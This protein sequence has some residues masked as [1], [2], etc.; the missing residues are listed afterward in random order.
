MTHPRCMRLLLLAVASALLSLTAAAQDSTSPDHTAQMDRLFAEYTV[1][2]S[3]GAAVG[4]YRHGKILFAKGY[5]LA[6][7]E[8]RTPI[9][10]QTQFHVASVSKQFA[11]F[12]VALLAQRGQ[13]DL[14]ADVR[15]YLP[16]F[17]DFG[18]PVTTRQLVHHTSG[19]RD[20]ISLFQLA[21][22]DIRDVLRQQQVVN[23]MSRQRS[24]NFAPGSSYLYSNMGYCLLAEIVQSVT[25]KSLRQ[26][27]DEAMFEPLGMTRT[28]F[29][30]D[31]REVVPGRAYSYGAGVDGR[32]QRSLLN[33]E[34]VGATGLFTTVEDMARWAG[35]FSE[36]KV[37]DRALIEQI[38]TSGRLNDGSLTH[39]GFGLLDTP[40]AGRKA[41]SHAGSDAGFRSFF[42]YFPE[43]D[44]SIAVL[45]NTRM[46]VEDKVFAIADLYLP[47]VPPEKKVVRRTVA[48]P[49]WFEQLPGTYVSSAN[50]AYLFEQTKEGVTA[51]R[52]TPGRAAPLVML[53]DGTFTF[54]L[55][56]WDRARYRPIFSKQGSIT[57]LEQLPEAGV[58]SVR[59]ERAPLPNQAESALLAL[60]GSYYCDELDVTY[61]FTV[62]QGRLVARTLWSAEPLRLTQIAADYFDSERFDGID[63]VIFDRGA[64]G[65]VL[66]ARLRSTVGIA[67]NVQLRRLSGGPR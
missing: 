57:A 60:T 49:K 47:P 13:L 17:P 3:P 45:A 44:V 48:A 6:D 39:Y 58:S 52:R 5:G 35:N 25:G 11:A 20:Q 27:T 4:V 46:A 51:R 43:H 14:D 42:V 21:G 53:A 64:D 2:G 66:G 59:F 55:G 1:E 15:R 24:L 56:D 30:D 54:D 7:L 40:V 50:A 23:L 19:V 62:E 63:A 16:Y 37:G 9:T 67:N 28:F 26:Y 36:P 32:W 18:A 38:G 22:R 33:F 61:Y 10:P 12:A 8:A 65:A 31:V 41:V 34:L 29:F